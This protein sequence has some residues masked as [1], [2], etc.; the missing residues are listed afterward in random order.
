MRITRI[1]IAGFQNVQ[2]IAHTGKTTSPYCLDAERRAETCRQSSSPQNHQPKG[3]RDC[4]LITAYRR[5]PET[6]ARTKKALQILLN[7][8]QSGA[9]M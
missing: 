8:V 5:L 6:S 3:E 2:D 7:W 4:V 1:L 9:V